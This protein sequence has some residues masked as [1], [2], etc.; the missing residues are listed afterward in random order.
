MYGADKAVA[1]AVEN[2]AKRNRDLCMISSVRI[3]LVG[4]T[5]PGQRKNGRQIFQFG[6]KKRNMRQRILSRKIA[7][8]ILE[9]MESRKACERRKSDNN[10]NMD[11][12]VGKGTYLDRQQSCKDYKC[13]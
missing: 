6:M 2:A 7:E 4:N 5:G 9:A 1:S 12:G 10:G 13:A 8:T 11:Y 3:S